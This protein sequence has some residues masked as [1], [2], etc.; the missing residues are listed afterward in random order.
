MTNT[1]RIEALDTE[2]ATLRALAAQL[3]PE[4]RDLDSDGFEYFSLSTA[5]TLIQP[6]RADQPIGR[7][8]WIACYAVTGNSEG[9]YIHVDRL[10]EA[11]PYARAITQEPLFLGK[12]FGGYA[13]ACEIAAYLGARLGV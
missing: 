1:N 13:R 6:S 7:Y 10:Y 4:I 3:E 8:R 9:H 5:A 12:T 11:E 2:R